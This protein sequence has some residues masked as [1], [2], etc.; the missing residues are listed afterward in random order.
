MKER[1]YTR[2][3]KVRQGVDAMLKSCIDPEVIR[4]G[5]VHLYGVGQ[6]CA[7]IA[8]RRGHERAY[9][10]LAEIAGMLHD[11]CK[12]RDGI[13]ERHGEL[14]ALEVK[15]ILEE[16]E[17][18]STEEIKMICDAISKHSN[19]DETD[20]EFDEIL[21]DADD[22]QRFLRNPAEDYFFQRERTQKVLR[23]FGMIS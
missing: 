11:Y 22:F 17:C 18:F 7:F 5:Y 4:C 12:Y 15:G 2:I 19:K 1:Q 23:E 6:T 9:A 3:D 21:K 10:E 16:L 13:E 14:S 8:L 20:T